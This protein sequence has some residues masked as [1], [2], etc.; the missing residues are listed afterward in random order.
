MVHATRGVAPLCN[1][2]VCLQVTWFGIGGPSDV[3]VLDLNWVAQA[4]SWQID[5]KPSGERC[6]TTARYTRSNR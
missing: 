5:N 1:S 3:G 4:I 2:T 6:E